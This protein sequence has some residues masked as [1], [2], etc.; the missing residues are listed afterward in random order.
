MANWPICG[1][2]LVASSSN[3]KVVG[4][5]NKVEYPEGATNKGGEEEE[6]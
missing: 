6:D 3:I 5:M 2:Q 4:W 1:H